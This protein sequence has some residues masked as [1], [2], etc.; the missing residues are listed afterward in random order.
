MRDG[1]MAFFSGSSSGEDAEKTREQ[2][3][4]FMGPGQVDQMVRHALQSCWMALPNDKRNL[5]EVK[6]QITR[7]VD[8]AIRDMEEDRDVFGM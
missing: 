2:M 3:R 5:D 4:E 8:R 6:R 1:A 7:L